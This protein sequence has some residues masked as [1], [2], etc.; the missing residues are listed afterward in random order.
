[1]IN[2]PIITIINN[3]IINNTITINININ[4]NIIIMIINIM[5]ITGLHDDRPVRPEVL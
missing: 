5:V 4:T 1:M 2:I 3:S